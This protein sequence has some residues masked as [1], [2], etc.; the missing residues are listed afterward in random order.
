[1]T[2]DMSN[3]AAC[4]HPTLVELGI[5]VRAV[6]MRRERAAQGFPIT[7]DRGRSPFDIGRNEEHCAVRTRHGS[8]NSQTKAAR[9]ATDDPDG[10]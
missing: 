4:I 7:G 9:H 2:Q 5:V 10:Q 3:V 8:E 6:V 1:M